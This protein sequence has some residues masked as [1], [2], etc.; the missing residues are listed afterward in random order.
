MAQYD[1]IFKY[2]YAMRVDILKV[3]YFTIKLTN[4]IKFK[5]K[6]IKKKNIFGKVVLSIQ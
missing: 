1:N 5:I 3:K 2:L 6:G 4:R